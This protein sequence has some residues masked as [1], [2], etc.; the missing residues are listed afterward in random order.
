VLT[1]RAGALQVR[2]YGLD[3]VCAYMGHIQA[4]AENAVRDML[5]SVHFLFLVYELSY[6]TLRNTFI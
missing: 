6:L 4:C 1:G 5:R 3:V 2:E